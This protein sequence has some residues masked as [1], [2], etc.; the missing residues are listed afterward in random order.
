MLIWFRLKVPAYRTKDEV[1][2]Y[3]EMF[4]LAF[5]KNLTSQKL[6]DQSQWNETDVTRD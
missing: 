5:I 1:A 3:I 2:V 4:M 6:L